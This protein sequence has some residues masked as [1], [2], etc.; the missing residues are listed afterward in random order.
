M[1]LSLLLA[2]ILLSGC[3]VHCGA[4]VGG[5]SAAPMASE[6]PQTW[7]IDGVSHRIAATYYLALPEGLQFTIEAP[8]EKVPELEV[9]ALDEGWPVIKHAYENK[10]FLRTSVRAFGSDNVTASRIG[11]SLFRQEGIH[12]QGMRAAMSIGD[13]RERLERERA[14]SDKRN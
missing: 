2:A 7:V 11:I 8:V 9:T 14:D 13:I 10:I 6:G 3:Q 4:N 5:G 12:T 1:R